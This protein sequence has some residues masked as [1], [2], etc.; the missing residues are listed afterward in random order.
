[1]VKETL[2]EEWLTPSL[3]RFGA[4]TLINDVVRQLIRLDMPR[5]SPVP[6]AVR[7]AASYDP[8]E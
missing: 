2:G 4:S 6:D 8:T 5:A 7:Y 1:M 3:F